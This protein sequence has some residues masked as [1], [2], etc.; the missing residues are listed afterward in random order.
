M[1]RRARLEDFSGPETESRS[2][3]HAGRLRTAGSRARS[4]PRHHE[5]R[6]PSGLLMQTVL[7]AEH[8]ARLLPPGPASVEAARAGD[9]S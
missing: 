5:S 8:F 1:P 6:Q 7:L 4:T 3:P 9:W 2:G